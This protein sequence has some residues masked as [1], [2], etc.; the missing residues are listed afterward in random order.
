MLVWGL[1]SVGAYYAPGDAVF[2]PVGLITATILG[3]FVFWL[4][5][6]SKTAR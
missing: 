2:E 5:R 4:N 6:N 3:S 1:S